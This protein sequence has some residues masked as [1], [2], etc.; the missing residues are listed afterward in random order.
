VQTGA[1]DRISA[2]IFRI[3]D[4][5]VGRTEGGTDGSG[6]KSRDHERGRRSTQDERRTNGVRLI[7]GNGNG[8]QRL[9]KQISHGR[10]GCRGRLRLIVRRNGEDVGTGNGGRGNAARERRTAATR[11]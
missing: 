8:E 2:R 11:I 3:D 6:R 5:C 4:E 7:R 9:R 10:R 1:D